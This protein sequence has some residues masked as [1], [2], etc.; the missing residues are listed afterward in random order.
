MTRHFIALLHYSREHHGWLPL[1]GWDAPPTAA[2]SMAAL[3]QI[4]RQTDEVVSAEGEP[5][6][7]PCVLIAGSIVSEEAPHQVRKVWRLAPALADRLLSRVEGR[8]LEE[9][10]DDAAD[11]VSV[12]GLD[13]DDYVGVDLD[14]LAHRAHPPVS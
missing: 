4:E 12:D 7:T 3:R 11:E 2:D 5:E 1:T 9:A 13:T 8:S 10:I 14:E 6:H